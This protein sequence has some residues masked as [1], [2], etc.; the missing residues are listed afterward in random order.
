M[1]RAEDSIDLDD[2]K[3]DWGDKDK[4]PEGMEARRVAAKEVGSHVRTTHR[5]GAS[6]LCFAAEHVH[7]YSTASTK[8]PSCHLG[9]P[10]FGGDGADGKTICHCICA[11]A[12]LSDSAGLPVQNLMLVGSQERIEFQSG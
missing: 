12:A 3:P 2:L 11:A 4:P 9:G 6:F 1:L 7:S 5:C 8:P 10:A